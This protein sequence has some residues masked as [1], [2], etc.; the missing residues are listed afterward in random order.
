VPKNRVR[1]E[2]EDA[3]IA[4]A[5]EQPAFGKFTSPTNQSNAGLPYRVPACAACGA[6]T[7]RVSEVSHTP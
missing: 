3:I 6:A 7:S 5:L 2:I 4:L 1:Q